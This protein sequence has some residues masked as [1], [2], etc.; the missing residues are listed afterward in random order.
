[1]ITK[2]VIDRL[3]HDG[4]AQTDHRGGSAQGGR[5]GSGG[6]AA[7]D[8]VG[9]FDGSLQHERPKDKSHCQYLAEWINILTAD[10]QEQV[11]LMNLKTAASVSRLEMSQTPPLRQY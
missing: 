7:A 10:N 8:P 3:G 11:Q 5:R 1:M 6:S 2:K 4:R 9:T